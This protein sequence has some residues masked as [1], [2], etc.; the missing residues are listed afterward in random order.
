MLTEAT[1][2]AICCSF[3]VFG[4]LSVLLYKPWRSRVERARRA[5]LVQCSSVE[6]SFFD[7]EQIPENRAQAATRAI[8]DNG[9][10]E[11]TEQ[12]P[13]ISMQGRGAN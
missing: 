10:V 7:A 11:T 3:V 13:S 1:G 8:A 2:G 12:A 6:M 9:T 5:R 4:G